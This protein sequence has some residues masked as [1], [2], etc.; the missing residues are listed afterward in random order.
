MI[1][2]DL[3][4]SWYALHTRSRF[5]NV[6]LDGL[7][8]KEVEVFLPKITTQSRRLDRKKMIQV[9]LFPGYLFVKTILNP[10]E[11]LKI[12]KT[13]GVVTFVG[14]LQGP[15]AI[16][17]ESIE[18]LK[19]MVMN[20]EELLSGLKYKHGDRVR[21][22]SGPFSGVWGEFVR[23]RGKGRVVVNI[24][25]LGQNAAVNVSED[26]IEMIRDNLLITA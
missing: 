25:A 6:V 20:S 16:P 4:E 19:I 24:A 17:M 10:F 3:S 1:V 26:D 13:I 14:N 18:S 8:R 21:V 5:E 12:V 9:P 22:I 11:H 7:E 23:Y 15:I 2:T